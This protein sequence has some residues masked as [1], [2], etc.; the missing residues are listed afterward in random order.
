[1]QQQNHWQPQQQIEQSFGLIRID[2]VINVYTFVRLSNSAVQK[3]LYNDLDENYDVEI[4][5][6]ML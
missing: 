2:I 3:C 6:H 5:T 1:M 4:D